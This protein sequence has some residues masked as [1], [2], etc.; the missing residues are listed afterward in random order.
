MQVDI[1][2]VQ[3][4][5]TELYRRPVSRHLLFH[6]GD[7]AGGRS[8]IAALIPRLTNGV[9]PPPGTLLLNLGITF[10]GLK[11]LRPEWPLDTCETAFI[12]GPAPDTMGDARGT[13][14]DVSRWWEG[15]FT[16]D[17]IGCVVHLYADTA[18]QLDAG[19]ADVRALAGT[20]GMTELTP[21]KSGA[22]LDGQALSGH[23]LHFGYVDG[24]SKLPVA[25]SDDAPAA[26][27]VN[28][29]NFV[30]GYQTDAVQSFPSAD[31]LTSL[32]RDS[33]YVIFR[34]LY[35]DVAA[36]NRY[37]GQAAA[38]AYPHL[39]PAAGQELA[40][41][42]LMGR[43]R[44]GTPLALAS[45]PGAAVPVDDFGYADDPRGLKCPLTAHVRIVNPRDQPLSAIAAIDGVPRVL[46]RGMPYGPELAG[47]ADDGVD[48]GILGIFICSNIQRQFYTLMRWISR[49]SFSPAFTDLRAQDAIAGNRGI[50][51]ASTR[52]VDAGA[53][54]G[55]NSAFPALPDFLHTKGTAFTLLPSFSA[56]RAI[57]GA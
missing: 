25:W 30:L 22:V 43:F 26:G 8:F 47:T 16:T 53:A 44:D 7:A 56:L 51:D 19:A 18:S 48:R 3:G 42:K 2:N 15:Q 10:E 4:L 29:R 55:G 24:I 57:A 34:W 45:T 37:V 27:T 12:D 36:F 54:P 39:D 1:T 9:T 5:A 41:A 50:P 32:L 49:A 13:P 38:S 52:F 33:S 23:R 21:R 28:F 46:R 31:P 11:L 6:F 17:A 14:S 40:A 20:S 35:Q